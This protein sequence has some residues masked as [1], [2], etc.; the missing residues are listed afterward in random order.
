MA[1]PK[2]LTPEQL[3]AAAKYLAETNQLNELMACVALEQSA[4]VAKELWQD[5]AE[6]EFEDA[7]LEDVLIENAQSLAY[8]D[9]F[10]YSQFGNDIEDQIATFA[11]LYLK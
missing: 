1:K 8:E 9:W 10:H 4:E 5:Q 7:T 6:D 3:M 11:C 2:R